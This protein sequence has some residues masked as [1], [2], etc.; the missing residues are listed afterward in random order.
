[1]I[2]L[3]LPFYAL[4]AALIKIMSEG[5]VLFV[6]DRVARIAVRSVLQ[7][8]HHAGRLQ[9]FAQEL[10]GGLH[11]GTLMHDEENGASSN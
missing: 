4:I 11:Q 1:V 10:R 5:P 3:G 6:Q 2:V 9:R 8:P 7:V